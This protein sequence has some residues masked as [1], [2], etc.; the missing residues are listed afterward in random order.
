[1]NLASKPSSDSGDHGKYIGRDFAGIEREE[2]EEVSVRHLAGSSIES[3]IVFQ[4]CIQVVT[5][6]RGGHICWKN[7]VHIRGTIGSRSTVAVSLISS[8]SLLDLCCV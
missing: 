3:L 1:M 5:K 8:E 6:I 7:Q 2:E 4:R